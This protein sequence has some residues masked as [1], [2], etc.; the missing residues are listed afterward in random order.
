ME[1]EMLSNI[2]SEEIPGLGARAPQ[3][4]EEGD[5]SGNQHSRLSKNDEGSGE[6][7]AQRE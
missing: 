4:L 6:K 3:H 7:E 5:V 1:L 2:V